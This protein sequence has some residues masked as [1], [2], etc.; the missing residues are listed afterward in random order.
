MFRNNYDANGIIDHF[1]CR[2]N[3]GKICHK[4]TSVCD[5]SEC[6]KKWPVRRLNQITDIQAHQ[7]RSL[8]VF[9]FLIPSYLDLSVSF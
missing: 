1:Y 2:N 9:F 5:F 6:E 4:I 7:T 8:D 3:N